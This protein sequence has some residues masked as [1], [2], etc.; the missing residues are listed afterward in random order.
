MSSNRTEE[1][2]K[3]MV[4]FRVCF[5]PFSSK[6][7]NDLESLQSSFRK[8]PNKI[9]AISRNGGPCVFSFPSK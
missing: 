2:A 1:V 9:S 3:E 7:V 6:R 8:A 5:F 4:V